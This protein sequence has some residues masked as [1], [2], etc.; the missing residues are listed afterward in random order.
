MLSRW[1]GEVKPWSYPG[2]WAL[3]T[4]ASAG[5]G[6][7]FARRLA[8][9][10]THLVLSARRAERLEALARELTA[11][12]GVQA[13]SVP[14]DLAVRGEAQRLWSDA[15]SDGRRIDL[16]V[17]NAGFGAQGRFDEVELQRHVDILEVNCVALMELAHLAVREMVSRGDGGIINVSSIAAFQPVPTLASYAA[18]KAF[19]LS[20]SEALWAE[21]GPRGVRVLA[22]CPGRTPTEFQAVAGTGDARGAF[23]QRTPADV[24]EAAL[25]ALEKGRSSVVPGVENHLA[26]WLVRLLPR[27]AVTRAAKRRVR[28]AASK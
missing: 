10:G 26:S 13:I 22:L 12:H 25:Q 23:G 16:L 24:V 20:L 28:R 18:A 11:G 2:R 4:G 9:R 8:E 15:S 7:I 17:N 14:A 27:S 6:E 21:N 19:T 1:V 5:L 3:V